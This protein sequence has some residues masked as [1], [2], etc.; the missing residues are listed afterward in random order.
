VTAPGERKSLTA[1]TAFRFVI[2]LG[3]A[4]GFADLT[5][6]GARSGT[7]QFLGS[8]GAS[9]AV[10]GFTAGLGELLGYAL[11]SFSGY[12]GD[13][14]G[15]YWLVTIAGYIVNML[16]VPA[17]ALAGNWPLAASLI[18]AERTGR[19]IRKPNTDAM[20]SFAGH[21]LGQ[22]WVFG[23]NEAL[24]QAG[25][26]L[27]PLIIS[28]VLFK[29]G[30][31]RSGFALLLISALITIAVVL[32][33]SYLFPNPRELEVRRGLETK[34]FSRAYW[35]YLIAGACVGAGFADFA[36][37][38]YHFQKT[39]SVA[40]PVIPIYYAIAMALGGAGALLFGRWFDRAGL[41]VLIVVIFTSAF[42]APLVFFGRTW[43]ALCGMIL[44]GIGMGAQN[45]LLKSV[46][47]PLLRRDARA[48]GFG[49]F[50]TGFGVAWFVGSWVMGI[51]YGISILGLVIFSV[52]LQLLSLI[53]FT[54]AKTGGLNLRI[55]FF[56]DFFT[57]RKPMD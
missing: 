55:T 41:S 54:L 21:K 26:T 4:N 15:K 33:A 34:G 5:Y 19:A 8:L 40:G 43:I 27:G 18:V 44:W 37:I 47:G 24:D 28:L 46:V 3:I 11:R 31:Y 57:T 12:L 45:S 49:V 23:L 50:D 25:A 56:R 42:F 36:L 10:I 30:S 39:G 7:G 13:K 51:L 9:A 48:T 35:L 17:L 29:H 14:T 1:A 6:E 16:A 20:L 53:P 32:I 38:A 22:G 2:I 52:A